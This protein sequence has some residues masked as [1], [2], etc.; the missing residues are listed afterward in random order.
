MWCLFKF[1]TPN[2]KSLF[3]YHQS[4]VLSFLLMG[5]AFISLFC[6]NF[7]WFLAA[8]LLFFFEVKSNLSIFTFLLFSSFYFP[9]CFLSLMK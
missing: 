5:I 9:L 8:D 2:F 4:E 1:A 7:F 6:K 3:N